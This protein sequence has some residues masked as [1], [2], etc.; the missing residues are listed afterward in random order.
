MIGRTLVCS[1]RSAEGEEMRLS[2]SGH[3]FEQLRSSLSAHFEFD[4]ALED[5]DV[6]ATEPGLHLADAVD[7]Y[8]GGSV[9]P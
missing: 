3:G 7:V 4:A 8:N 1:K 5:C 2:V 6:V 9:N